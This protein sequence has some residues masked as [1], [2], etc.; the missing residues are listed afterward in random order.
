[1]IRDGRRT[2]TF[3]ELMSNKLEIDFSWNHQIRG[4][5]D[6]TYDFKGIL[7]CILNIS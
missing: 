2:N 4:L 5:S 3:E 7:M 6:N 1:M